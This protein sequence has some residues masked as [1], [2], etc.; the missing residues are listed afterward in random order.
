MFQSVDY[1]A[2]CGACRGARVAPRRALVLLTSTRGTALC[3]QCFWRICTRVR[4]LRLWIE[5]VDSFA[6]T[7]AQGGDSLLT[8][9]MRACVEK[10]Y[11][12]RAII[13]EHEA[14][15]RVSRR[16]C[17]LLGLSGE[18]GHSEAVDWVIMRINECLRHRKLSDPTPITD[19][20]DLHSFA[21]KSRRARDKAF[22]VCCLLSS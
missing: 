14:F 3:F 13:I 15:V 19:I 16:C 10:G 2:H 7:P 22:F 12:C 17:Y 18:A 20:V 5:E 8:E 11:A 4:L 1:H 21:E 9:L 6:N